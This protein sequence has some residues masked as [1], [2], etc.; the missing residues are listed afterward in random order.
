MSHSG[1]FDQFWKVFSLIGSEASIRRGAIKKIAG[2][3]SLVTLDHWLTSVLF[4][5]RGQLIDVMQH[6]LHLYQPNCQL[7]IENIHRIPMRIDW[8]FIAL[9]SGENTLLMYFES[10]QWPSLPLV[11]VMEGGLQKTL[12]CCINRRSQSVKLRCI[13]YDE[14]DD[15]QKYWWSP[16]IHWYLIL[17]KKMRLCGLVCHEEVI[18]SVSLKWPFPQRGRTVLMITTAHT[19]IWNINT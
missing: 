12:K 16:G 18:K 6:W 19:E 4:W 10:T 8:N 17:E 15:M 13:K 14:P 11:P 7:S 3:M 2:K 1:D 5:E 9:H